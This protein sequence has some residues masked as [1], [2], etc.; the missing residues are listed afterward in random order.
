MSWI[1]GKTDACIIF[2]SQTIKELTMAFKFLLMPLRLFPETYNFSY[3]FQM[4]FE[5][6]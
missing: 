3:V 5:L 4:H 1:F 2:L 6:I